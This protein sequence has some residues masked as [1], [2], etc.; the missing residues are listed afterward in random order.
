MLALVS[1]VVQK[2]NKHNEVAEE[3]KRMERTW[4]TS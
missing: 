1:T 2:D 4:L 3:E